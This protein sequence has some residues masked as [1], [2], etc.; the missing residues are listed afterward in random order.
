MKSFCHSKDDI[1]EQLN[2]EKDNPNFKKIQRILLMSAFA[3]QEH[4]NNNDNKHQKNPFFSKYQLTPQV[5]TNIFFLV[6]CIFFFNVFVLL[7]IDDSRK[8]TT[9]F[10]LRKIAIKFLQKKKTNKQK[11]FKKNERTW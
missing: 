11:K 7:C 8:G 6:F 1:S 9:K 2:Q 5:W 4:F 10:L 3:T